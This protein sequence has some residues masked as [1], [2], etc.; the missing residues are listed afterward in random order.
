MPDDV[1]EPAEPGE[2][3]PG[4]RTVLVG[5]LAGVGALAA[6]C[7]GGAEPAPPPRRSPSGTP[8]VAAG[9]AGTALGPAADVPVGG[10]TVYEA[11]EVVVTQ[12]A[13]GQFLGFSAVCTHTGCIVNRVAESTIQCPCHGSRYHLDGTVA[14]GPAPRALQARPV[15]IVDGQ[16][17]LQ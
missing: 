1:P 16:I 5:G 2:Q 10:G 17:V 8:P 9:S 6:A 12:P 7:G 3:L 14:A 11:L 15:T 13:A 4:R